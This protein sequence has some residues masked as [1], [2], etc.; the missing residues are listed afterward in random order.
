[1][2]NT[3]NESIWTK[4]GHK[5]KKRKNK[6]RACLYRACIH[7]NMPSYITPPMTANK[8]GSIVTFESKMRIEKQASTLTREIIG[9]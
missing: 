4:K 7:K 3:T 9:K 5:M 1:M 8:K 6:I 2:E